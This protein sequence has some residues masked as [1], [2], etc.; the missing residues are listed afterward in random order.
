M[1]RSLFI[2]AAVLLPGC[3]EAPPPA[4]AAPIAEPPPSPPVGSVDTSAPVAGGESVK[5]GPARADGPEFTEASIAG[6]TRD[7]ANGHF[8]LEQATAGLPGHGQLSATIKTNV[9]T[10]RCSLDSAHAPSSV[11]NFVGL[12]RGKRPWKNPDGVWVLR[13]AYDN[14]SFHRVIKGFMIQGGDPTGTGTGEPG[15]TIKDERWAGAAHDRAGLLCMANRGPDTNGM[16]F[17]ITDDNTPHLDRGKTAY[18]IFGSCEPIAVV[19]AIA[20]V[21]VGAADRPNQP[22]TIDSVTIER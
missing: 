4:V 22:V 16:Q 6:A 12:A 15:Y 2:L 13:P 21:S 19:H 20:A 18:T 8:S 17:F 1:R 9:G 7:P 14:T 5:K 10:M 3:A 11:A